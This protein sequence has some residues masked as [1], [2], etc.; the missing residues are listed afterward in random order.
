MICLDSDVAQ[1]GERLILKRK[2]F[3]KAQ[4]NM[5][6]KNTSTSSRRN[7]PGVHSNPCE[8]SVFAEALQRLGGDE[9]LLR[10]LAAILL[11]DVPP[12]VQAIQNSIEAGDFDEAHR[13]A[14]AVKGLVVTFD[15]RGCG[16]LISEV[17]AALKENDEHEVHR[18]CHPCVEAVQ[19][20]QSHCERLLNR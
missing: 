15:E 7:K 4:S 16:L 6:R 11:D 14:H 5:V 17:M 8:A 1:G 10:E 12:L 20:L 13:D 3:V 2:T 18:L 19:T 9:E